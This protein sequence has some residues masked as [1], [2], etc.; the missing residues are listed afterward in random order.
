M[1]KGQAVAKIGKND[2][3]I[4]TLFDVDSLK[5]E[6]AQVEDEYD[7]ALEWA[8]HIGTGTM[9]ISSYYNHRI[10]VLNRL[11][12]QLAIEPIAERS[13]NEYI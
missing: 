11:I 7:D 3:R 8:G 12:Q 10:A 1:R 5:E 13:K 9:H 4:T 6:L 2:K